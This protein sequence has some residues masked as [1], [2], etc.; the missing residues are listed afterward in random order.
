MDRDIVLYRL[1]HIHHTDGYKQYLYIGTFQVLEDIKEAILRLK[2]QTGFN[3][4]SL[5]S[6]TIEK[7]ILNQ[8]YWKNGF[9][10][11]LENIDIEL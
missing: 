11:L 10:S 1:G 4:Y 2:D 7:V 5:D 8:L 3:E 9:T 6:F